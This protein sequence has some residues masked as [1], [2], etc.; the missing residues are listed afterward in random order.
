MKQITFSF[1][2]DVR[3]CNTLKENVKQTCA[4]Y[5]S[6]N[7]QMLS[8]DLHQQIFGKCA[9]TNIDPEVL[10]DVT[11]HLTK[12]NLADAVSSDYLKAILI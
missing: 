12:H 2:K 11:A 9:D 8:H 10:E 3:Y 5:N 4:R 7:I 1:L 6:I